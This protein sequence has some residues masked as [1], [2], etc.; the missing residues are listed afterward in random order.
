MNNWLF[1]KVDFVNVNYISKSNIFSHPHPFPASA[2]VCFLFFNLVCV[3]FTPIAL[4]AAYTNRG[5]PT[6]VYVIGKNIPRVMLA[7]CPVKKASACFKSGTSIRLLT[8]PATPPPRF[9]IRA[10]R[11]EHKAAF[12]ALIKEVLRLGFR[13]ISICYCRCALGER[14]ALVFVQHRLKSGLIGDRCCIL[15]YIHPD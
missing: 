13:R 6:L 7:S 15:F 10:S 11:T 12:Y 8:L 5:A 14:G 1:L 9:L 2:Y 3:D 4:C